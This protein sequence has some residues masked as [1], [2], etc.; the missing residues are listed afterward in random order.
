MHPTWGSRP[1]LTVNPSP[2][3]TADASRSAAYNSQKEKTM[4]LNDLKS[5][6]TKVLN[7]SY[8]SDWSEDLSDPSADEEEIRIF[9]KEHAIDELVKLFIELQATEQSLKRTG[10]THQSE[11]D[12]GNP[13]PAA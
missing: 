12:A 5:K 9:N 3:P 6:I 13:A 8:Y 1:L 2:P 7:D 10:A 4:D 11:N